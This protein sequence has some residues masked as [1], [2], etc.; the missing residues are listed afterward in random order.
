MTPNQKFLV[1]IWIG[2]AITFLLVAYFVGANNRIASNLSFLPMVIFMLFNQARIKTIESV[3]PRVI[4]LVK[5]VTFLKMFA[6]VVALI[7]MGFAYYAIFSGNHAFSHTSFVTLIA[8]VIA[9][10]IPAIIYSQ[11]LCYVRLGK[12]P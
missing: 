12:V 9:P 2:I 4:E 1:N 3:Y 5:E 6:V 11:V 7:E 10:L 8:L